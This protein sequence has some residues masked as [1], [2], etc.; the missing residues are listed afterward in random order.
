MQTFDLFFLA[1]FQSKTWYAVISPDPEI[2]IDDTL[3]LFNASSFTSFEEAHAAKEKHKDFYRKEYH[4]E[5]QVVQLV[6]H[7]DSDGVKNVCVKPVVLLGKAVEKKQ[8]EEL[9]KFQTM[10]WVIN[11]CPIINIEPT[12]TQD[13]FMQKMGR[14]ERICHGGK[15]SFINKEGFKPPFVQNPESISTIVVNTEDGYYMFDKNNPDGLLLSI[16][17]LEEIRKAALD[18]PEVIFI[19]DEIHETQLTDRLEFLISKYGY[20]EP[21]KPEGFGE[22]AIGKEYLQT[23]GIKPDLPQQPIYQDV[24]LTYHPKETAKHGVLYFE[25]F[26]GN[27][28]TFT[29]FKEAFQAARKAGVPKFRCTL[30]GEYFT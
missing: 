4:G 19:S 13:L 8:V 7:T 25:D 20:I 27:E 17:G 11:H 12:T 30:G 15:S 16:K 3:T 6:R 10:P 5:L 9:P 29:D 2:T 28:Q 23:I 26:D 18:N 1:S 21:K 14:G 24:S 22:G